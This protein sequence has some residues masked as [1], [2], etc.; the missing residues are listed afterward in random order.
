MH[1]Q[2]ESSLNRILYVITDL[3]VGGVPLHLCRLAT[4]MHELGHVVRVVSLSPPGP[5]SEMLVQAGVEVGS[6]DARSPADIGALLRLRREIVQFKPEII[7]SFLFHAN[8]ACRLIA[9]LAGVSRDKL[10]CEIQT[11]EIERRWHLT[12]DRWTHRLC[13]MEIGNSQSVIDH[14]HHEAGL[15]KSWLRLVHGG[16]DLERFDRARPIRQSELGVKEKD[17]LLAWVGRLDP[18]KGLEDLLSALTIIRQRFALH[19][20]LVGDGPER[21]RLEHM[22]TELDLA[23]NVSLVGVRDNVPE[24][25][26]ACDV[27]IFPSHTEGMPNALLEAMAAGCAIVCTDVPGNRDLITDG[28]TGLTVPARNP[29]ALADAVVKLLGSRDLSNRLGAAASAVARESY[30]N[31]SVTARYLEIYDTI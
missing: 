22:I 4:S 13:R 3:E 24:I 30:D 16:V 15:P 5:V 26:K 14:L 12:V 19:L 21:S 2:M 11:V 6:C 25:L 31:R 28:R 17:S 23:D 1:A 20:V 10:I 7:H 29:D 9:P 8:I 18:V 27:F